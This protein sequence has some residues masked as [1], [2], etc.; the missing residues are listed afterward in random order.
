M[1]KR[2]EILKDNVF[3]ISKQLTLF[4]QILKECILVINSFLDFC[5]IKFLFQ[6]SQREDSYEESIRDLTARLK[7]VSFNMFLIRH[8]LLKFIF[9]DTI[10]IHSL[11][12]FIVFST[13][14]E[15]CF[16]FIRTVDYQ[17]VKLYLQN[18]KEFSSEYEYNIKDILKDAK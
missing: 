6:A 15:F 9:R 18:S 12:N 17:R 10:L 16:L 2:Y 8:S 14:S 3:V 4:E 11:Q 1:N 7:D 13:S 5:F